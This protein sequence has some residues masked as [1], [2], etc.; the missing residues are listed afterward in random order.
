MLTTAPSPPLKGS[1]SLP[2]DKSLSHRSALFA[3]MADGESRIENFLVAGV[4]RA[5]L[6]ALGRLGFAYQLEGSRLTL[7]GEGMEGWRKRIQQPQPTL[8]CGHSATSMRLLAGALAA[9]GVPAV[10][11]GSAGLRTRPMDR[12]VLPLQEMGVPVQSTDG[13]APLVFKKRGESRLRAGI[14]DLNVASAQVKSCLLLAGL[15]ADGPV[16]VREPGPS[17]DHT[18]R[19]LGGMGA[20][21]ERQPLANGGLLVKLAP[22]A[23]PLSPLVLHLPGD[24]S[25]AAFLIIA[26]LVTPGSEIC[27]QDVGLNPTRTGLLEAL[28]EMGADVLVTNRRQRQGEP[29]GDIRVRHSRLLACEVLGPLVV[30]MIDEFPAFAVAA[31]FAEGETVV[32]EA[33]ELRFKES[34]RISA[35]C[36]QLRAIGVEAVEMDDG[37]RIRGGAPPAGGEVD[38][39]GDHRLAMSLAVAG[40]AAQAPVRVRHPEIVRQSFPGFQAALIGLGAQITDG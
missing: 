23:G 26:A 37:F 35:L 30:R 22:L 33:R 8:D 18:E 21:I 20:W 28:A 12:I 9:A 36:R 5:M 4:T 3:A 32:R 17:R 27:L 34:D 14:F 19:L 31:A 16:A 24:F 39:R 13:C 25:S 7:R 15:D 11:D 10:L 1:L 38:P 29:L 40:L 2:G 6:E